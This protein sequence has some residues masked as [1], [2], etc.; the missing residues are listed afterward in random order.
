MR[1]PIIELGDC[2][3][4]G[5]CVEVCPSVFSLNA[6]DYIQISEIKEYPES[7]VNEAIKNCPTDCISWGDQ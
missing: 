3:R 2:I 1:R 6:A 5:I 4:C 7:D